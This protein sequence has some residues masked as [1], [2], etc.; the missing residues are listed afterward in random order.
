[1]SHIVEHLPPN[2]IMGIL[3]EVWRITKP[4]GQ[5]LIAMPYGMSPRALQDPTHFRGWTETVPQYFDPDY[6]LYDVYCPKPWRI[7]ENA[8]H[9]SGDLNLILVKRDT[10]DIP[11]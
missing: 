9:S 8:W 6:P 10:A 4:A 5:L 1:M 2:E 3:D 7:Q 11:S